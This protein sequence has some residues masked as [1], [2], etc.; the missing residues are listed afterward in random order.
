VDQRVAQQ[1]EAD[2]EGASRLEDRDQGRV[3][4]VE[5]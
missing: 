5:A 2:A 3:R 1:I 4:R